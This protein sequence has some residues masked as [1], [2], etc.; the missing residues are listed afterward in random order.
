MSFS[1]L[2]GK[3]TFVDLSF[4]IFIILEILRKVNNFINLYLYEYNYLSHIIVNVYKMCYYALKR[5]MKWRLCYM[6]EDL[7]QDLKQYI[8]NNTVFLNIF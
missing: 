1:N 5:I 3:T 4:P 8:E 6:N 2:F 7:N